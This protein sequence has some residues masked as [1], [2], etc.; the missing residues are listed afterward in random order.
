MIDLARLARAVDIEGASEADPLHR[1][2]LERRGL[3]CVACGAA[4]PVGGALRCDNCSTPL[5]VG[6]LREVRAALDRIAPA[7]RRHQVAPAPHVTAR[8]LQRQRGDIARGRQWA[9][10][11]EAQASPERDAPSSDRREWLD[12]LATPGRNVRWIAVALLLLL[13]L[14]FWWA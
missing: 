2:P 14:A 3:N 12:V 4:L 5:A 1:T 7:L 13:L 11:M 6:D 9:R 8:R 10:E